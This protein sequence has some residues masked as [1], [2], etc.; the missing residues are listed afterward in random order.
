MVLSQG[1]HPCGPCQS[2]ITFCRAG[3]FRVFSLRF[4]VASE[5]LDF[6]TFGFAGQSFGPVGL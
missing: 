5:V 1:F 3:G 2:G 6:Q 4:S